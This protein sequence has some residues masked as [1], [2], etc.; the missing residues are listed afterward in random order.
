MANFRQKT[1]AEKITKLVAKIEKLPQPL[2]EKFLKQYE[3]KILAYAPLINRVKLCE[4]TP[5]NA[6]TLKNLDLRKEGIK[7]PLHDPNNNQVIYEV[8]EAVAFL[9]YIYCDKPKQKIE[10]A[11]K[12]LDELKKEQANSIYPQGF[13]YK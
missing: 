3:Q 9:R 8:E 4:I 10:K 11:Q 1:I 13:S 12:E 7:N 6:H 5:L 2:P